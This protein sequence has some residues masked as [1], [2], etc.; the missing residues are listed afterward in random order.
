MTYRAKKKKYQNK[1]FIEITVVTKIPSSSVRVS[2]KCRDYIIPVI[3]RYFPA[4]LCRREHF[5]SS[6]MCESVLTEFSLRPLVKT[7]DPG[8]AGFSCFYPFLLLFLFFQRNTIT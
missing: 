8:A 4:S 5:R 3:N 2:A 6:R 7:R 1:V